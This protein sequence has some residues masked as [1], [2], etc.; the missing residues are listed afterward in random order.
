MQT[1][2]DYFEA[3]GERVHMR[4]P[5]SHVDYALQFVTISTD[6]FTVRIPWH[7]VLTVR[8]GDER[9]FRFGA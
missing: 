1:R 7:R 5:A 4:V 2:V 8:T 6:V 3:D 9:E